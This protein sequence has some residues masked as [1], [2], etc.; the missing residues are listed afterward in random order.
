[1]KDIH[2]IVLL[3][4]LL[5]FPVSIRA[6]EIDNNTIKNVLRLIF[7]EDNTPGSSISPTVN[8]TISGPAQDPSLPSS[9]LPRILN[10]SQFDYSGSADINGIVTKCLT[11]KSVYQSASSMTQIPWQ[12]LAGIHYREGGCNRNQSLVGGRIIGQREPDVRHCSSSP[13][14]PG[15]PIPLPGGGC[16]FTNL[17]SSAVYAGNHL[18]TKNPEGGNAVPDSFQI[19]VTSLGR[20]NGIGNRNCNKTPYTY[21]PPGYYDEDH[22]YP[23]NFFDKDKHDVMYLVYCADY[24]KCEPPRRFNGLGAL[25]VAAQIFQTSN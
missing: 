8:P 10:I 25:T 9:D 2:L 22:P 3:I 5:L 7:S 13:S 1:M 12:I 21:C 4:I 18:K 19:L 24:T 11:N 17:L 20:Y 14:G 16:G 23:L 15:I 6:E